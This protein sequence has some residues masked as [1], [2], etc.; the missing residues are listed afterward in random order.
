MGEKKK[1]IEKLKI[2]KTCL[3]ISSRNR[4]KYTHKHK[5]K[6]IAKY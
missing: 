1:E 4:E 3:G 5:H 2:E 6:H